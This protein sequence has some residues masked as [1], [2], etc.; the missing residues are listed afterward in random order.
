MG[1]AESKYAKVVE[2]LK[3]EILNGRYSSHFSFPSVAMVMRRFGLANAT[4]VKALDKL[5]EQGFIR[6]HQG[7]GTFITHFAASRKIG[8]IMPDL[9][10]SEFLPQIASEISRRA[11]ESEYALLFADFPSKNPVVRFSEARKYAQRLVAEGV[12]GV[13]YQPLEFLADAVARNR[14]ITAIFDKARIPVVLTDY[15]FA[16]LPETSGY[17]VVGIDDFRA[18]MTVAT[19]LA[20]AG[21]EKIAYACLPNDPGSS[22]RR[23]CGY[24][25]VVEKR[26]QRAL[27]YEG[28]YDDRKSI[29]R[30][31]RR[32]RPDAIICNCDPAAAA[33]QQTLKSLRLEVPDDVMLAGFSDLQTARLMNPPLTT[34]HQPCREI[35]S[36]AF[37]RLL[38]RIAH[39]D[40]PVAEICLA[41]PLVIR[42]SSQPQRCQSKKPKGPR[43]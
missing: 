25:T 27:L 16:P 12:S 5:K 41:A 15:D 19:H 2:T 32:Y 4:A 24:K 31:M 42:D 17:D 11:R 26:G 3:G 29:G 37:S 33:V 35:A 40:L 36:L 6:A 8:L 10:V 34:I 23:Y 20:E 30:F 21:A 13:I 18:G 7:R 22:M 28:A 9:S 43:K 39:P 1:K 14:S 38:E